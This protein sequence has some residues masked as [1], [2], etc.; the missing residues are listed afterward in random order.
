MRQEFS[1]KLSVFVS[2]KYH[3]YNHPSLTYFITFNRQ[4]WVW[5]LK[6]K[7]DC[8]GQC[9]TVL[10]FVYEVNAFAAPAETQAHRS[11]FHSLSVGF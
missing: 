11:F 9:L 7:C 2:G 5:D 8:A 10:E 6:N 1:E 4:T 3:T